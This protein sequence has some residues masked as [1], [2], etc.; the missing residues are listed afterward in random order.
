MNCAETCSKEAEYRLYTTTAQPPLTSA[1]LYIRPRPRTLR[2]MDLFNFWVDVELCCRDFYVVD[3]RTIT[4]TNIAP[5]DVYTK[6][7]PSLKLISKW[8]SKE[9]STMTYMTTFFVCLFFRFIFPLLH[10]FLSADQIIVFFF[11]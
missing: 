1:S 8:A 10:S 9:M 11:T 2:V 6:L 3:T 7:R 5:A 4:Q